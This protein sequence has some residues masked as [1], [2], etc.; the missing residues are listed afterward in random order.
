MNNH[1]QEIM[2]KVSAEYACFTC[3][4][5]GAERVSYPVMTPSAARG[6]LESIFWKPEMYFVI[7]EIRILKDI[8]YQSFKRNEV[9]N[10]LDLYADEFPSNRI[11]TSQSRTQLNTVA[12]RDVEY[13]IVCQIGVFNEEHSIN[14]Y[15]EIF[16]RRLRKGQCFQRPFLGMKEFVADFSEASGD[17]PTIGHTQKIGKI[18]M[19]WKNLGKKRIPRFF[20]ADI[21]HGVMNIPVEARYTS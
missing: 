17:E 7:K 4:D 6:V 13:V 2:V 21:I 9:S 5:F 19:S 8:R 16:M 14:K 18:L 3:P 12:L 20:D 1:S 11:E 15:Y 10:K